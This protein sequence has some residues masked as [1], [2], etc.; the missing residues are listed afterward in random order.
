MHQLKS[1][2]VDHQQHTL[3]LSRK[4]KSYKSKSKRSETANKS[5]LSR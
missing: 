4:I 5:K 2:K 3:Q 1:E